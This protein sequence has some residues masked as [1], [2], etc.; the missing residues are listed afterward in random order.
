M[1]RT[2][3]LTCG[4]ARTSTSLIVTILLVAATRIETFQ[5][6]STRFPSQLDAYFKNSVKLTAEEQKQLASGQPVTKLLDGDE[7]KEVAVFGPLDQCPIRRYVDAVRDIEKFERGGGFR[8]TK[9]ISSPAAG[10]LRAV[11]AARRYVADLR[12]CRVGD[13]AL[14][15]G[16]DALNRFRSQINWNGPD[17]GASANLLMRQIAFEYV[18]RYLKG[19]NDSL[20]VYRDSS[21]PTFVAQELRSM[22]DSMPE[23]TTYMP[24]VRKHLLDTRSRV[25]QVQ[26]TSCTGRKRS[27]A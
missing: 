15:L 10:G 17:A 2:T 20:A 11:A 22:V 14:K 3:T 24:E 5:N 1:K 23:L 21:H 18:T 12:T 13:C 4:V 7:T 25:Y 6:A 19:G 9:R 27:S 26:P 16:E 8:I